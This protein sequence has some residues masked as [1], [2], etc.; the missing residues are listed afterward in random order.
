MTAL[1]PVGVTVTLVTSDQA[2]T[3][4]AYARLLDLTATELP[5]FANGSL[6]FRDDHEDNHR[7]SFGVPDIAGGRRLMERRGLAFREPVDITETTGARVR[8]TDLPALD[9]LV[10][11][12]PTRDRALAL[13]GATLDLDFR[14]DREIG[15]GARQLFFRAADVVVEVITGAD[16]GSDEVCALWGLAWRA[17]DVDAVHRRLTGLDIELSEVRTGRK[18]GTRIFTVRDR[19]LATRTVVI[20]PDE[21]G[22]T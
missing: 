15:G 6:Q 18:P 19:A 17:T 8:D 11:T 21:M 13:F 1:E 14:L 2:Q 20:G 12:A 16:A 10:F 7:V 9:H 3:R 5:A 22:P 4:A